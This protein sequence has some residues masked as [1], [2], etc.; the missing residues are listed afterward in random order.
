MTIKDYQLYHVRPRYLLLKI[1][2]DDGLYGWGEPTLEGQTPAVEAAIGQ[3]MRLI[4]GE[5]PRRIEHLWQRMYRG[6]FYRGGPVLCSAISGI[7]QALW[8][9]LGKSLN[10]P[11]YQLLGGRVRDRIRLYGQ[12]GSR[13]PEIL[14]ERFRRLRA[15]GMTMAKFSPWWAT[16][17]VDS[18][19]VV[20]R[21]VDLMAAVREEAGSGFDLALDCHGRLS[22][23]MAI[24]FAKAL[25]PYH[26]MFLEEPCLPENVDTM[27]TVARS[28]SIPIA[29]GERLFTRWGFREV[30]E[31]QAAAIIQ[32]DLSHIGGIFEARKVAAMAEVYYAAVAPHCPLSAVSL[33]ACLQLAACIPN[34]LAQE[35]VSLGEKLLVQPFVIQDGYVGVPDKPGLGIEVDEGKLAELLYDGHWTTPEL[36]HD[37]GSVADW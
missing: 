25:E 7:E 10:V 31:K 19:A 18:P 22:P 24:R 11:V 21:A 28:T 13:R 16:K 35:H 12:I 26:P 30:L 17:I 9:I 37:D 33:A 4:K 32:P 3:L 2:T 34:F 27:V 36:R 5:D 1:E 20:E 6:G 14:I 23:A 15:Q 29:T 8:D